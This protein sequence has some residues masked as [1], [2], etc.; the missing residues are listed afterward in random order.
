MTWILSWKRMPLKSPGVLPITLKADFYPLDTER[1]TGRVIVTNEDG[2]RTLMDFAA[3][4][5]PDLEADILGRDFTLNAIA[6]NL[7]TTRSMTRS[8][9][10]WT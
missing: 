2:T 1:D 5:G 8:V 7:R 9:G 10:Q 6:F 4:R 3:F